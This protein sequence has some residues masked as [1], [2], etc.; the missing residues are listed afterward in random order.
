MSLT[1]TM[2]V[3]IYRRNKIFC[4]KKTSQF[5]H[6]NTDTE[7]Q[8]P[9]RKYPFCCDCVHITHGVL[10]I[11]YANIYFHI[12]ILSEK[13]VLVSFLGDANGKE[14]ACQCRRHNR[15]KFNHWVRK[16]PWRRAWQFTSVF[17]P[18]EC[19]GQRSLVNYS[20][21]SCKGSDTTEVT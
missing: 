11:I 15:H 3:H 10:Y 21:W 12:T 18:G 4:N 5:L 13:C 20:P 17:L 6:Y 9:W 1:H 2:R 14:P 19:H 16:I 8:V 7:I